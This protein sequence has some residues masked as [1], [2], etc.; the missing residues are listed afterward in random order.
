MA[1]LTVFS[2]RPG[3]SALHGLDV[4]FKL[5]FVVMLSF[6]TLKGSATA[7]AVLTAV[8]LV[9]MKHAGL[10]ATSLRKLLRY[11]FLILGLVFM[12]RALT[13]AGSTLVELMRFTVTREGVYDGVMVCWR[14]AAVI[15]ISLAFVATTRP[16]EIKSALEWFLRPFPFIP[17]K[18]VSVMMSLVMRFLPVIFEQAK[19]T[20]DAQR[21]R[22]IELRRN[23]V[24]RMQK[25]GI[26]VMR[27]IF[28]RAD[29][30][31]LAMEARCYSENR[32]DAQLVAKQ[33]D[34]I[35]LLTVMGLCLL[36]GAV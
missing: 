19:E 23:P 11:L 35:A 22:G 36:I 29:K 15:L 12:A 4:R 8:L 3:T 27:R 25:L 13:T 14:L 7:L 16:S 32:T 26:P 21:A 2:Y 34:W 30:L 1:E 9:L 6:A 31:A 17:G 33:Q 24:Y 5:I 18:R 10:G 20:L 28:E